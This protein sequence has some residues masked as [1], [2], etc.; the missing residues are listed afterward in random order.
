M[1]TKH[2]TYRFDDD[3]TIAVI[4]AESPAVVCIGRPVRVTINSEVDR[5]VAASWLHKLAEKL[6]GEIDRDSGNTITNQDAE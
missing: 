3:G 4:D 5:V 6:S 2:R 1:F